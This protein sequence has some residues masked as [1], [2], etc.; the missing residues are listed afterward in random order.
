MNDYNYILKFLNDKSFKI[1][2]IFYS[3]LAWNIVIISVHT[4]QI[5]YFITATCLWDL[6]VFTLTIF[7][8]MKSD[9]KFLHHGSLKWL[10]RCIL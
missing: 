6:L 2:F 7:Q 9:L 10:P 1:F 4:L 3:L 8:N 5:L